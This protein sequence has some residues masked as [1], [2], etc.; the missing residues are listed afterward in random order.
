MSV[1]DGPI[2]K[3]D[4]D[5]PSNLKRSNSAPMINDMN[6]SIIETPGTTLSRYYY[7]QTV[8]LS[9]SVYDII[10]FSLLVF[11]IHYVPT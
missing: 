4:V 3:M 1:K 11:A 10:T 9:S 8:T 5:C 6:A 7:L 2:V